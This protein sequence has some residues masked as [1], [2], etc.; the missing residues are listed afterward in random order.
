MR[1]KITHILL[2][3]TLL[4]L[5]VRLQA[6]SLNDGKKH[7]STPDWSTAYAQAIQ[8]KKLIFARLHATWC[9][10]CRKMRQT[11]LSDK[12]VKDMLDEHCVSVQID[13]D[14][15]QLPPLQHVP[16]TNSI[17]LFLFI[18]PAKK[19]VVHACKGYM[20]K[21]QFIKQIQ[22]AIGQDN[23]KSTIKR[24]Q[25]TPIEKMNFKTVNKM[26]DRIKSLGYK[27]EANRIFN[28]I[29]QQVTPQM[30]Q[31]KEIFDFFCRY[32]TKPD[33]T[34]FG[35]MLEVRQ[36][37]YPTYGKQRVDSIVRNKMISFLIRS[38]YMDRKETSDKL[39][40][41]IRLTKDPVVTAYKDLWEALR[42]QPNAQELKALTHRT[43]RQKDIMGEHLSTW[44]TT[45]IEAP[46]LKNI[47]EDKLYT[48]LKDEIEYHLAQTGRKNKVN[49]YL[50]LRTFYDRTGH[51]KKAQA[52]N[53]LIGILINT[54]S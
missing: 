47:P 20:P 50:V 37:L 24:L 44:M 23:I 35:K 38:I 9:G 12:E 28:K 51:P 41:N 43:I 52:I 29:C 36:T 39:K 8:Q 16:S 4:T 40:N 2:T 26:L 15:Q 6:S 33:N 34:L 10:P 11:V 46:A 18:D 32:V 31:N 7:L 3:I 1:N 19:S 54:K 17:P 42:E 21:E 5:T 13:A 48:A 53:R 49:A 25:E 45:L 27:D 14:K 22:A 30:I